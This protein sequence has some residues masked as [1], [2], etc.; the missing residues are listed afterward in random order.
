MGETFED[1][2]SLCQN[3]RQR[4]KDGLDSLSTFFL[5]NSGDS[6]ENVTTLSL[7]IVNLERALTKFM[8]EKTGLEVD[9]EIFRGSIPHGLDACSVCV[10]H[11]ELGLDEE[12][13]AVFA[14]FIC[15]NTVR[16]DAIAITSNLCRQ[17]PLSGMNVTLDD[18][19]IVKARLVRVVSAD[20]QSGQADNGR[21]KT[22]GL[23]SF[24]VQL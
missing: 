14:Q 5:N 20:I 7:D 13:P 19:T 24:K 12:I 21:L 16:N 10:N 17:F 3:Y 2:L 1:N 18:G 8:A 23:I 9:R 4:V 11:L 6:E 15:R 22:F